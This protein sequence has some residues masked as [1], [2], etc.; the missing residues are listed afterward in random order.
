MLAIASPCIPGSLFADCLQAR[1]LGSAI[2]QVAGK[3]T[4]RVD[5]DASKFAQQAAAEYVAY[6]QSPAPS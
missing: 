2:K 3:L 1:L 4:V 5:G 6:V